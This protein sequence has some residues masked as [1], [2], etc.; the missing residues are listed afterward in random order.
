[1]LHDIFTKKKNEKKEIKKSKIIIDIHEKNSLIYSELYASEEIELETKSLEIGDYLVGETCIERKTFQDLIGS[2][3]SRRIF[4]QLENL[5]K[6]NK[7]ILIIEGEENFREVNLNPNAIRGF[8]L[9]VMQ[10]FETPVLRTK[11]SEDTAKYLITLA[12][13]QEKPKKEM[14]LHSRIPKTIG[15]QKQYVLES[16]PGVGPTTAKKLIEKYKTLKNIFN[17]PKKLIE[18]EIGK[19]SEDF[20]KVLES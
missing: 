8:I 3:I 19:K 15:E 12:K 7:R 5:S 1:M 16:F 20:T 13:Q 9:S 10:N 4:T 14:S 17:Q 18:E 11:N 2:I 6:Y